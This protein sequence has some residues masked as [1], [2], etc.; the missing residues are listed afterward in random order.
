MAGTDRRAPRTPPQDR[1]GADALA[2]AL[3]PHYSAFRVAERLLFTG[4]SHQAWPDIARDGLVASFDDAAELVDTKWERG[5]ARIDELRDYLRRWYDDPTGQYSPAMN[6]HEL[7]TKW[8]S[9]LDLA[10]RPRI[11]TSDG[12]FHSL[13]R[14]LDRLEEAGLEVVR[15]AVEP[16]ETFAARVVDAIDAH[17]AAVMVSR[18]FYETAVI[19]EGI[20]EIAAG[21]RERSVPLMVDDYHGTNVVPWSLAAEGLEDVYVLIGGYKYL[22]WG[23]G[24]CFLRYPADCTMRPVVTGWFASFSSLRAPRTRTVSYDDAGGLFLGGTIDTV[25]AY[26]AS[27]VARFF[28]AQGLDADVLRALA[29]TNVAT[30]RET[31]LALDLDPARVRIK[32]DLPVDRLGG[33]LSLEAPDAVALQEGL[34]ARGVLTDARATTLR[35]GPAPYTTGAQIEEAISV[36]GELARSRVTV[37]A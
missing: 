18:V 33:F 37:D 6:T 14:Q 10:A 3:H 2:V 35:F 23:E 28:D 26:R 31:F 24:N 9:A 32:V 27:E 19:E 21:C 4:H 20:R 29:R 25:S 15:V 5:F 36:L 34:R 30:L 22:Q 16:R 11:V 1:S 17:T 12:E 7:L 8:L 13:A